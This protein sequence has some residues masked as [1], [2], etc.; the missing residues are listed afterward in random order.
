MF[1]RLGNVTKR[2]AN[3]WTHFRILWAKHPWG[4]KSPLS[5]L[6][7]SEISTTSDPSPFLGGPI[8]GAHCSSRTPSRG[9]DADP[10][11]NWQRRQSPTGPTRRAHMQPHQSGGDACRFLWS[12]VM[13]EIP[14]MVCQAFACRGEA[15]SWRWRLRNGSTRCHQGSSVVSSST[16]TYWRPAGLCSTN[17][18][19]GNCGANSESCVSIS[20]PAARPSRL[21][22]FFASGRRMIPLTVFRKQRRHERAEIE[23]AY[24]AMQRCVEERHVTQEDDD[25]T[26]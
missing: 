23:R 18:T 13:F 10:S 16:S 20:A 26:T 5:H 14:P 6:S 2:H 17:L 3:V 21:S 15:S 12:S 1:A 24:K 9:A 19:R 4:F 22:Y 7:W 8:E 25:E 11:V